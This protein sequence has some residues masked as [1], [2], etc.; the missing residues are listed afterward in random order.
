MRISDWSSDVCS[1]DLAH[2]QHSSQL[3][4]G[5]RR[6]R[7]VSAGLRAWRQTDRRNRTL[8][9]LGAR[10]GTDHRSG[11]RPCLASSRSTRSAPSRPR[12]RAS[13]AGARRALACRGPRHRRRQQDHRLRLSYGALHPAFTIDS[14]CDALNAPMASWL[15][16]E[17][18]RDPQAAR[19]TLTALVLGAV[20]ALEALWAR[21]T[22][23]R[24]QRWFVNGA[25]VVIAG[26]VLSLLPIAAI[27]VAAWAQQP[28]LGVLGREGDVKGKGVAVWLDLGGWSINETK[29]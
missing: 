2:H 10:S 26:L 4:A 16:H 20:M 6:C 23:R 18:Q 9:D 7:S 27:G 25:L 11:H 1:S 8:R 5:V 24:R 12:S 22:A 13:G 29:Q 3:S 14:R 21:R 15:W 19:I 17:W 28:G